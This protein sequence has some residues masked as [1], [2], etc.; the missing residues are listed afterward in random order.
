[1]RVDQYYGGPVY[2]YLLI[3]IDA[4]PSSPSRG[5][6]SIYNVCLSSA[7]DGPG[8]TI[9]PGGPALPPFAQ[10]LATGRGACRGL[11]AA[12]A[13]GSLV[14]KNISSCNFS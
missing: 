8:T 5:A 3:G 2:V 13:A 4:R 1:V 14:A 12:G 7:R 6:S 9:L 11:F 10:F